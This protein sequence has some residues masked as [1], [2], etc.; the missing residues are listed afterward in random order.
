MSEEDGEGGKT[1]MGD[2]VLFATWQEEEEE[3]GEE[4]DGESVARKDQGLK[5]SRQAVDAQVEEATSAKRGRRTTE[6][7]IFGIPPKE[8][9]NEVD[10]EVV[11][12]DEN[13]VGKEDE[14]KVVKEDENEDAKKEEEENEIEKITT[15]IL[16]IA[17]ERCIT[18]TK[19]IVLEKKSKPKN[20]SCDLDEEEGGEKEENMDAFDR[21]LSGSKE[22]KDESS[23]DA[24]VI[25]SRPTLKKEPPPKQGLSPRKEYNFAESRALLLPPEKFKNLIGTKTATASSENIKSLLE[26]KCVENKMA[27]DGEKKETVDAHEEM[28][29]E[30]AVIEISDEDDEDIRKK[31]EQLEIS[32]E[33]EE[34]ESYVE[35][36]I[37]EPKTKPCKVLVRKLTKWET[38][39]G[40]ERV[41]RVGV[42]RKGV[43][44]VLERMYNDQ[45]GHL[46]SRVEAETDGAGVDK[47]A[48]VLV[49]LIEQH[50]RD[51]A[52]CRKNPAFSCSGQSSRHLLESKVQALEAKVEQ[53][54]S[55][56]R[57][58]EREAAEEDEE[59]TSS[60]LSGVSRPKL[61]ANTEYL[62]ASGLRLVDLGVVRSSFRKAEHVN[63]Y[64][65]NF[66]RCDKQWR[67]LSS[68]VIPP[69]VSPRSLL[70]MLNPP[71]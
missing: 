67:Q 29:E 5:R 30:D 60:L 6:D 7:L 10:D 27:S 26:T 18:P 50:V 47:E 48:S 42:R 64:L 32:D 15:P 12:E 4:E 57:R 52:A 36:K 49:D 31:A 51:C 59:V 3:E 62:V 21:L 43:L 53:L 33:E 40:R 69:S 14:N 2:I 71:W 46:W 23:S 55:K 22:S 19:R 39:H 13:E 63:E 54:K 20:S 1:R 24:E 8:D 37:E 34:R 65:S 70:L 9:E 35:E 41:Q 45:E 56:L 68:A 28:L 66:L 44:E 17:N 58:V 61:L 38:K 16:E 11:K 25:M